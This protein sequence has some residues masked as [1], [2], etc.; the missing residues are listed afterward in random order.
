MQGLRHQDEDDLPV[1]R[2]EYGEGDVVIVA[3][4]DERDDLGDELTRAI[5]EADQST[6]AGI[7]AQRE[8]VPAPHGFGW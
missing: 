7:F 3:I 4:H 5:I 1:E 6:E 8:R 2:I